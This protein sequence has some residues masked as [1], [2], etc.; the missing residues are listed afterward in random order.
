MKLTIPI[1]SFV[2]LITNSSTEIYIQSTDKTVDMVKN[3]VNAILD[4]SGS[5]Y[6]CDD[7]F[8][9][10]SGGGDNERVP[11]SLTVELVNPKASPET[12]AVAEA[13]RKL[14]GAFSTI[15]MAN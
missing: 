7:L 12:Q 1:H 10:K 4:A 9:I 14:N 2:D 5:T 15:E 8:V 13:I 3:L 6:T 11:N